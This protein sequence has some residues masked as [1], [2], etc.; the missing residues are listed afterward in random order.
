MITSS[1][2]IACNNDAQDTIIKSVNDFE[3]DIAKVNTQILDVR[4]M[5]EYQSG[6]IKNALLADWTKPDEFE[7][8]TQSLDKSKTVYVYC[9][10]GARSLKAAEWLKAKGYMVYNLAGGMMAWKREGKP[11][12]GIN[13]V[14]QISLKEYQSQIPSDKTVLVDVG[15]TWCPPC[16]KMEPIIDSLLKADGNRFVLVRINGG[17]QSEI[18]KEIKIDVFPTFIIYKQGKEVWRDS[19]LIEAKKITASF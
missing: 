14:K 8:R 13:N 4:T 18:C 1:S 15:A 5:E 7:Y 9:L 10:S 2:L 12:E 3:K 6:H 16:K 11:I 19:G 17:E